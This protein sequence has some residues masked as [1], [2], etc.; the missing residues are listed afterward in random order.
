MNGS[1]DFIRLIS[2]VYS[3]GQLQPGPSATTS[4]GL[5]VA[6]DGAIVIVA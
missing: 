4:G 3:S 6:G 1:P 5:V 2:V